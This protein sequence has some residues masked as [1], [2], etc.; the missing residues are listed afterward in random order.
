MSFYRVFGEAL[1]ATAC[2]TQE[3]AFFTGNQNIRETFFVH[4]YHQPAPIGIT[5]SPFTFYYMTHFVYLL[6]MFTFLRFFLVHDEDIK[7]A[8]E[9][10]YFKILFIRPKSHHCLALSLSH[11]LTHRFEF[12]LNCCICQTSYLYFSKLLHGFV[13]IDTRISLSFYRGFVKVATRIC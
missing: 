1:G 10:W 12:C 11:S 6:L 3:S 8:F 9:K 5:P 13:K 7:Q 2:S 4:H